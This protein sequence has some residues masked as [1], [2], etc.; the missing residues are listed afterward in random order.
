[1]NWKKLSLKENE[2][3]DLDAELKLLSNAENIK[4]NCSAVY[5]ELKD[6]D[7]PVVQQLK[8]CLQ[9]KLKGTWNEYHPD[10]A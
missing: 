1:M 6:S 3:E 5:F 10:I 7:T 9:N 2:L 4:D 8:S